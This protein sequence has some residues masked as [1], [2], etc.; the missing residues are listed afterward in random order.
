MITIR[1]AHI[2]VFM[3][4]KVGRVM[5]MLT[6]KKI[7]FFVFIFTLLVILIIIKLVVLQS[8]LRVQT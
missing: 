4:V 8:I 1:T 6:K 7:F 5:C 2:F 3:K